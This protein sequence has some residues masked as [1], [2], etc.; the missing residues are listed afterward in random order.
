MT[1]DGAVAELVMLQPDEREAA[2]RW[3]VHAQV[4]KKNTKAG[5]EQPCAWCESVRTEGALGWRQRLCPRGAWLRDRGFD[6]T[7]STRVA[8]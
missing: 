4:E 7:G 6:E 8:M 2:H 5:D 3:W 1:D